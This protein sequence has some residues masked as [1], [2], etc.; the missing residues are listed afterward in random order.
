MKE[1]ATRCS[2]T[3]SSYI[4]GTSFGDFFPSSLAQDGSSSTHLLNII[5]IYPHS[6]SQHWSP[7]LVPLT[8]SH[9]PHMLEEPSV[10][11]QIPLFEM[12][13]LYSPITSH[14]HINI[15]LLLLFSVTLFV[16]ENFGGR[17]SPNLRVGGWGIEEIYEETQNTPHFFLHFYSF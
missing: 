6:H 13:L 14:T 8:Q 17:R 12:K 4:L 15:L 1:S 5:A 3:E 10:T 16:P 2:L 7:L 9:S 11:N